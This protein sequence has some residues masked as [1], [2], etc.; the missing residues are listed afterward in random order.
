MER[1]VIRIGPRGGRIVAT[2]TDRQGHVRHDYE[3]PGGDGG[4]LQRTLALA[5]PP[6]PEDWRERFP[7]PPPGRHPPAVQAALHLAEGRIRRDT[8]RE[9]GIAVAGD[10]RGLF[11]QPG[12]ARRVEISKGQQDDMRRDGNAVFAHNHPSGAV[13]SDSD[14]YM[15]AW[16]N[17]AEMRACTPAGAWVLRRP[18]S[19]WPNWANDPEEGAKIQDIL[20]GAAYGAPEPKPGSGIHAWNRTVSENVVTAFNQE[21]QTRG[22]RI[23]WEPHRPLAARAATAAEPAVHPGRRLAATAA[24]SAPRTL[25][26]APSQAPSPRAVQG[27]LFGRPPEPPR[28]P[29]R[30]ALA[31]AAQQRLL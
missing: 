16:C 26:L 7:A 28:R 10:G 9:H 8:E 4:G 15:A 6:A 19:G 23:E 11:H 3:R 18:L 1:Q 5:P 17:L 25:T 21:Y 24:A 14:I 22:L 27:D 2:R 31:P 12:M 13:L 20:W 30:V 29:R